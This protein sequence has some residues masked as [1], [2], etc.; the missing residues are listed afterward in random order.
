MQTRLCKV[1]HS[2]AGGSLQRAVMSV[3]HNQVAACYIISLMNGKKRASRTQVSRTEAD[4]INMFL[5]PLLEEEITS[6]RK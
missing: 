6:F 2:E 3:R 5:K 4:I 1:H